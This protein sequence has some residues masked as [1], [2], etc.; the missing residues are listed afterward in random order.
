[1]DDKWRSYFWTTSGG[2]TLATGNI[3]DFFVDLADGS[4]DGDYSSWLT[5]SGLT[6][7]GITPANGSY[8][9]NVFS[10]SAGLSSVAGDITTSFPVKFGNTLHV[11]DTWFHYD[12]DA[13]IVSY[14]QTCSMFGC[15]DTGIPTEYEISLDMM[16]FQGDPTGNY[17]YAGFTLNSMTLT[18]GQFGI[19]SLNLANL[20]CD[21]CGDF[22]LGSLDLEAAGQVDIIYGQH[23]VPI[24]G[25][26]WLLG[27]GLAGLIGILRRR[28]D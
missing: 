7:S 11:G 13:T 20:M 12:L 22:D 1:M 9:G 27:S 25:A 4:L 2:A 8:D 10:L 19:L 24:P 15:F 16:F 14:L 17:V 3:G 18:A 5:T 6:D 26:V 28:H 23:C 21:E